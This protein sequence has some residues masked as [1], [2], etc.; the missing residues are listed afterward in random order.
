MMWPPVEYAVRDALAT[1]KDPCMVA[2]GL[3]LSIV[4][5][6][7]ITDVTVTGD[8]ISIEITFTEVG[9]QF[10]HLVIDSIYTVVEAIPG[11]VSVQVTPQ[12]KKAW[13]PEWMSEEGK[14]AFFAA[15]GRFAE[16]LKATP[17]SAP[18]KTP[19]AD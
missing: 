17:L 7:L 5:L 10:T 6:G 3:D 1:I 8:A 19:A 2:G 14:S 16:R 15:R 11:V 9:C 13:T 18:T 12:W 4:D